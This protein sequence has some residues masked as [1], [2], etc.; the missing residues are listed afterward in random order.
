[1]RIVVFT[2]LTG[3]RDDLK[4]AQ[5]TDGADFVA[6]CDRPARSATWDVRPACEIFRDPVRNAKIHKIL[7]HLYFPDHD[8]SLWIDATLEL[9]APAPELVA[10]HL[11][12]CDLVFGRHAA[13]RTLEDELDACLR[14]TLD[15]PE[16][17]REQIDA[18]PPVRS[19]RGVFPLASVVLRRHSAAVARFNE[20]WWA[21]ICRWSRRDQ[22][23]LLRAAELA[24]VSWETFARRAEL[25]SDPRHRHLGSSYF[26]WFSHGG[27]TDPG[28]GVRPTDDLPPWSRARLEFLERIAGERERYA[29]DLEAELAKREEYARSLESEVEK[30]TNWALEAERYAR[31]LEEE[32]ARRRNG[33]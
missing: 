1:M 10:E 6:F 30:R 13:H 15:D 14:E 17:V 28:R 22:L 21:E 16:T 32:I 29:L 2:A 11:A 7:P 33:G 23:S 26:R 24:G 3:S 8:Y 19:A 20:L 18:Y 4:D 27:S 31:S 9:A 5:T 25:E 12:D